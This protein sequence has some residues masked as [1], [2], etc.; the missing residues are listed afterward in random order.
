MEHRVENGRAAAPPGEYY[1]MSLSGA[2]TCTGWIHN[3]HNRV[4][5]PSWKAK[6]RP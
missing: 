2:P 6:P 4:G 3:A 1:M 5:G